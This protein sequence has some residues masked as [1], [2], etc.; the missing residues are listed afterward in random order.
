MNRIAMSGIVAAI[1]GSAS[2]ALLAEESFNYAAGSIVG[3]NGGAGWGNSWSPQNNEPYPVLAG[4]LSYGAL[5]TSGNRLGGGLAWTSIG[6]A[7]NTDYQGPFDNAGL[8]SDPWTNKFVDTGVVYS[9]ALVRRLKN[10]DYEL[11]FNRD[12]TS[13]FDNASVK[14]TAAGGNW[15]LV[16]NGTATST[17]V[18]A[19]LDE[20]FFVVVRHAFA[21]GEVSLWVNPVLGGALQG[22]VTATGTNLGF[23]AV[24]MYL[25]NGPN[26]GEIDELRIG[27]DY[28]S[29]APVPEPAS[30]AGL[31]FAALLLRRRNRK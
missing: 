24:G 5:V 10:E 13:W 31:A 7:L 1:A 18:S 2:A 3:G 26:A 16:V 9:S 11:R 4:S 6:R 15:N 8:V 25:G 30:L 20:T 12:N 14:V 21:S 17:G 19:T 23:K 29:V 22:G 28:A 27:T